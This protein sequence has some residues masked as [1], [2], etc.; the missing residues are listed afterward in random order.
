MYFPNSYKELSS[1][2]HVNDFIVFDGTLKELCKKVDSGE[3]I[4][5][6]QASHAPPCKFWTAYAVINGIKHCVPLIH[7]PTGCTY[8]VARAYKMYACNYKGC[9][10]EPT[11]CTALDE[12]SIVFGGEGKLFEAAQE[13]QK[14]FNPDVIV[15]L[16][17]CCSGIIGDDVETVAHKVEQ[18]IGIPVI[19]IRS[20]GFGGDFRSGHEEAFK[21]IVS[22]MEP[23]KQIKNTINIVGARIGPTDTE[24][25]QEIDEL[26][27]I[28]KELSI[29]V[30]S[31]IAG[32]CTLEEIRTAPSVE[33]NV[34]W[35]YDWGR[36][37]GVLMEEK[38]GVPFSKTGLPYGEKA[39]REWIMGVAEP[40][41]I[42]K[43]ALSFIEKEEKKVKKDIDTIHKSIQGKNVLIEIA[44]YPG[45]LRALAL[46]RMVK[47]CNGI[48]VIINLHPYT[49]KERRPSIDFLLEQGQNPHVILTKGL[50]DIGTFT[51][52]YET[53]KEI[54]W[55]CDQYKPGIFFANP[56]RFPSLPV[57]N[58]RTLISLPHFGYKG[59]ENLSYAIRRALQGKGTRSKIFKEVLYG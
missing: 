35:C 17:C 43:K 34:S 52:S 46:A 48:P 41:G 51:S 49:V 19:A 4:P 56:L 33:L 23:Q 3:F 7:G 28:V 47:E 42:E 12:T 13:A 53:E 26:Y 20:E 32:G 54:E 2:Y 40:M 57:V 1:S 31:I 29:Q 5:K 39:T 16:S 22:L 55:I 44:E 30:H 11:S 15:I 9:P 38:F 37:I 10:I 18:K 45:P 50:F 21:A 24:W 36:K 27:R 14:K 6:L 58:L 59:I 25:P 8:S